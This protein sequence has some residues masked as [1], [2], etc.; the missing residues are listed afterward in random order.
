MS[1]SKELDALKVILNFYRKRH[2]PRFPI[3]VYREHYA[4]A[5]VV[6]K[7]KDG[8]KALTA[9]DLKGFFSGLRQQKNPMFFPLALSQFCLSLRI[10]EACGLH[11][12]DFDFKTRTVKIQ[13]TIVWDY[14]TWEARIKDR[15][16]NGKSRV[17]AVPE[18]LIQELLKWKALSGDGEKLVFHKNGNPLNRQTV[19]KAYQRSLELSGIEGLSGTH[20]IRRSSATHANRVTGDFWAVSLNLGHSSPE[21]TTRYVSE[22]SEQKL[23][24][25]NALNGV[26]VEMMRGAAVPHCP[27]PEVS[28]KFSIVKSKG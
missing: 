6:R 2:D 25:A 24:V 4:A 20:L 26:A 21:E 23:K 3:P 22:V 7:S 28:Q 9:D 17:L 16:K 15:P 11:W 12:A 1:F 27:A 13:N 18:I 8:I 14:E 19:A 5:E 10:G